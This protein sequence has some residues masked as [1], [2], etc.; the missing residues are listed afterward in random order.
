MVKGKLQANGTPDF[1]KRQIGS[2][3]WFE[4]KTKI[5][6][7]VLLGFEY[8]LFINVQSGLRNSHRVNQ[9]I[10][11]YVETATLERESSSEL[12]YGIKNGESK[13]IGQLINALNQRNH[14]IPINRYRLSMTTIEEVFL[15]YSILSF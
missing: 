13:P 6:Q 11:E 3:Y 15:R 12:V 7:L 5:M 9:F 10:Q 14:N 4:K 1:L 2:K 8:C